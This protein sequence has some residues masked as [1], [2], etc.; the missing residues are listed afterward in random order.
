[1]RLASF[2]AS[3]KQSNAHLPSTLVVSATVARRWHMT[4]SHHMTIIKNDFIQEPASSF[5]FENK[6]KVSI[7]V[8]LQRLSFLNLLL[9]TAIVYYET[10][11]QLTAP[12]VVT[13]SKHSVF[14]YQFVIALLHSGQFALA[15]FVAFAA[16]LALGGQLLFCLPVLG[17]Q[18]S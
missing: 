6:H 3:V 10:I 14:E 9:V 8:L 1:M 11:A 5:F 4:V 15:A 18:A 13:G 2:F 16:S 7:F 17:L 12:L